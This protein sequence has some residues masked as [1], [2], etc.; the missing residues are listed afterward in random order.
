M[1][2]FTVNYHCHIFTPVKYTVKLK[3]V[4]R[5]VSSPP[6]KRLQT[7]IVLFR[8]QRRLLWVTKPSTTVYHY[9][10]IVINLTCINRS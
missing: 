10:I 5:H 4:V 8:L 1:N 9:N 6:L 2:I 7:P 3:A